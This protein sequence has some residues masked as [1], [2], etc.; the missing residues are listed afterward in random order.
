MEFDLYVILQLD[1]FSRVIS[2]HINSLCHAINLIYDNDKNEIYMSW[3]IHMY[4]YQPDFSWKVEEYKIWMVLREYMVWIF[5]WNLV[6]TISMIKSTL[7]NL[8]KELNDL[9][10]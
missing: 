1:Q 10:I 3:C 7:L 5:W 4:T 8:M 2:M 6:E 9:P